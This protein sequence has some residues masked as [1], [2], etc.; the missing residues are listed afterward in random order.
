ME[1]GESA[2]YALEPSDIVRSRREF[3]PDFIEFPSPECLHI[4]TRYSGRSLRGKI[5]CQYA[6]FSFMGSRNPTFAAAL[7][8]RG[9]VI[10]SAV[11]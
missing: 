8:V 7:M 4:R 2:V 5:S 11:V 3:F 10:W 1:Q 9:F 6:Y